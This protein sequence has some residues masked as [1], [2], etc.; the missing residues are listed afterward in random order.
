M[1]FLVV[2]ALVA[3][4]YG[5]LNEFKIRP[6]TEG[7]AAF[8]QIPGKDELQSIEFSLEQPEQELETIPKLDG[9][10]IGGQDARIEQFGWQLSLRIQRFHICGA[11]IISANRALTAAH[12]W[13]VDEETG[14]LPLQAYNVLAGSTRNDGDA[15]GQGV[16]SGIARWINHPAYNPETV[17]ADVA[18]LWLARPFPLNGR[19]IRAIPLP[20]QGAPLAYGA[21]AHV[22]GW[23]LQEIGND[24]SGAIVLQWLAKPIINNRQCNFAY[25]GRVLDTMFCAGFPQGGRDT[26]QGDSGGP[27]VHNGVQVGVVSWGFG[28][29]R[30]HFPGVY[31]RVSWFTNWIRGNM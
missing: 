9:R 3:C 29:A 1:K 5:Q 17:N 18:V 25:G 21:I 11:S 24:E 12:C 13:I 23:G 16:V 8:N 31:V 28:C 22:S 2:L 20:H 14:P 26:C 27:L 15:F 19:T 7:E 4:A 6:P 10:I 30:P